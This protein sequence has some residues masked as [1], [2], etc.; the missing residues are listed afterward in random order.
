[1]TGEINDKLAREASARLLVLAEDGDDPI[2]VFISSPGG[3]VHSRPRLR[4]RPEIPRDADAR[5]CC[6]PS[7][8]TRGAVPRRCGGRR[9]P[10]RAG[11]RGST[12]GHRRGCGCP[13]R[14]G[15]CSGEPARTRCGG[16]R[17]RRGSRQPHR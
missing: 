1:I 12:R 16:C 11:C 3:H 10:G 14:G 6:G 4:H 9:E 17:L 15:P 2:N 8:G 5:R 13:T 7:R